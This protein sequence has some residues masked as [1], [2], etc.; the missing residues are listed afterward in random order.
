MEMQQLMKLLLAR[1]D[2]NTRAK[3]KQNRRQPQEDDRNEDLAR[4]QKDRPR[5]EEGYRFEGKSRGNE[6]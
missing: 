2:A 4:R 5:S 1:M 6:I 3:W